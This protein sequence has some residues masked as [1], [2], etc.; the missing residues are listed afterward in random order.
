MKSGGA[1]A[2]AVLRYPLALGGAVVATVAIF[3]GMQALVSEVEGELLEARKSPPIQMVRVKHEAPPV[4]K[5]RELPQKPQTAEEPPPPSMEMSDPTA[6]SAAEAVAISA[7]TPESSFKMQG[8]TGISTVVAGDTAATPLVRVNPELPLKARAAGIG[9][10]VVVRFDIGPT[11][12][13]KNVRIIEEDPT[14]YGFGKA[15]KRAVE[16]W[17]YRPKVIDGQG[18]IQSGV[19]TE[20]RFTIDQ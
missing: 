8:G 4:E 7:P 20:L 6:P 2:I 19:E 10:R 17:K 14:G 11:G 13:V 9:G 18:V 16:R 15:A 3:F 1:T 12:N 5:K